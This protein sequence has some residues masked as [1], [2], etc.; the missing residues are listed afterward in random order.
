VSPKAKALILIDLIKKQEQDKD[1]IILTVRNT[2]IAVKVLEIDR[3]Y[4]VEY[5]NST[6][7]REVKVVWN[8]VYWS[9]VAEECYKI[10]N[11]MYNTNLN[12]NG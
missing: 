4:R 1:A 8:Y 12:S 10:I 2:L 5:R 11:E 7:E 3:K 9:E 6:K